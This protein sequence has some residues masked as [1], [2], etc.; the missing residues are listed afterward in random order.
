MNNELDLYRAVSECRELFRAGVPVGIAA[1]DSAAAFGVD[2]ATVEELAVR[3]IEGCRPA[4]EAREADPQG[5]AQRLT[6]PF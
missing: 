5:D 6:A 2:A 3:A 4:T 1:R